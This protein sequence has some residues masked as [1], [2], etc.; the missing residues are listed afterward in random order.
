MAQ[1][2]LTLWFSNTSSSGTQ[3]RSECTVSDLEAQ[4]SLECTLRTETQR[5]TG[6]RDSD[7][8]SSRSGSECP[9]SLEESDDP[10]PPPPK[11]PKAVS[12]KCSKSK[13]TAR[14]RTGKRGDYVKKD[15]THY[16]AKHS[17]LVPD[18]HGAKGAF[19]KFTIV[20]VGVFLR[21]QM[22]HS[23]QSHS[24]SGAKLQVQ[25]LGTTSF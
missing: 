9:S 11:V 21:A 3:Q 12:Y 18:V 4:D 17:W 10:T 24:L 22:V 1:K 16:A 2:R 23:L 19:C 7:S 6:E 13:T 8:E 25:I 14:Y 20:V 15:C 5:D